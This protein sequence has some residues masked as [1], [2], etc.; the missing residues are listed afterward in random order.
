[1][2]P[3]FRP[4]LS[5]FFTLCQTILLKTSGTYLCIL[6]VTVPRLASHADVL[7]G[8]SRVPAPLTSADLS[9]KTVDQSQQTFRSG[10]CTLDL[11]KFRAWLSSRKDQKGLMQGEDLT[12]LE[13]TTQLTHKRSY[14]RL[15]ISLKKI[16]SEVKFAERKSALLQDNKVW[17]RN[18][19][20]CSVLQG[21]SAVES[22][23]EQLYEQMTSNPALTERNI[24]KDLSPRFWAK[25]FGHVSHSTELVRMCL[26][27]RHFDFN[28][29]D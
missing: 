3:Y 25:I 8:S 15:T 20:F 29:A 18:S 16:T 17:K 24:Q 13:Q 5:D 26:D 10:K 7:T 9:G 23:K 4:K 6:Y 11:E 28:S 27:S 14:S 22:P 19:A 2:I 12:V 1:M 21:N